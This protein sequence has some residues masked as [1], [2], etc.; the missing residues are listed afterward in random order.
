[1]EHESASMMGDENAFQASQSI[2]HC[3]IQDEDLEEQQPPM[4]KARMND[5]K[6][7]PRY[8]VK[9][10]TNSPCVVINTDNGLALSSTGFI[11][12]VGCKLVMF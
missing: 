8:Y 9:N 5:Y 3:G 6:V 2:D 7:K 1:M 10:Y 12:V 4:K 11:I